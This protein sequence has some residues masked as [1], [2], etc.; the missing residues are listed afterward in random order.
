MA[1]LVGNEVEVGG[2]HQRGHGPWQPQ[3]SG[4]TKAPGPHLRDLQ[5]PLT[6]QSALHTQQRK[7]AEYAPTS[8]HMGR[9]RT[10]AKT[11]NDLSAGL[12]PTVSGRR[13][14]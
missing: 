10:T 7:L 9:R 14:R 8:L 5:C 2:L 3:W 13:S 1:K 11:F 4:L 12:V 6:L